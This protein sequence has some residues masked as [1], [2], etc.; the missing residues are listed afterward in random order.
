MPRGKVNEKVVIAIQRGEEVA[1]NRRAS[2]V[3]R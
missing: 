3:L 2:R 1:G